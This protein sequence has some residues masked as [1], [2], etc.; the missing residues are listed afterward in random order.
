M[1]AFTRQNSFHISFHERWYEF[2][3]PFMNMDGSALTWCWW[4]NPL[5]GT[6]LLHVIEPIWEPLMVKKKFYLKISLHYMSYW[7]WDSSCQTWYHNGFPY[8]FVFSNGACDFRELV[9]SLI[10]WSLIWVS[11]NR[12]YMWSMTFVHKNFFIISFL[13]LFFQ[14]ISCHWLITVLLLIVH[15]LCWY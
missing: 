7:S 3:V 6:Q 2:W 9:A 1:L 5:S 10:R 8:I 14:V 13:L 12:S 4:L 15:Y 11:H